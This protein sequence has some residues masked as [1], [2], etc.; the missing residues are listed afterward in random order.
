M[1]I[2]FAIQKISRRDL[3]QLDFEGILKHFSVNIPKRYRNKDQSRIL[4]EMAM[5]VQIDKLGTYEQEWLEK[6]AVE[7]ARED[8]KGDG[9]SSGG[10]N[11]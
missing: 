4:M 10:G 7:F 5:G 1:Q 6:R 8:D 9:Q 11:R 3:L 2:I